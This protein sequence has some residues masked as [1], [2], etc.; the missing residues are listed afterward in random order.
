MQKDFD[1][2]NEKKKFINAEKS[3]KLY[4]AREIWWCSFGL[5]IGFE[6]DGMGDEYQRPV[7]ILKGFSSYTCLAL[8]L[9]SSSKKHPFRVSIGLVD[10]KQAS[11]ILSQL[12]VIDTKRL[13]GK[14]GYLDREK[15]ELTRKAV[16]DM[17]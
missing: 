8:P 5:N 7:L 10:G 4:H 15:F 17:L 16:K 1:T 14:V 11:A 9:T 12:R 3:N 6:H 13:L 2:W